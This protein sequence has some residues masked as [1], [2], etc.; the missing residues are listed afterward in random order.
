M[1]NLA[2]IVYL[3]KSMLCLIL[4]PPLIFSFVLS[5]CDTFKI[6][7]QDIIAVAE[8]VF[9]IHTVYLNKYSISV[10]IPFLHVL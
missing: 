5:K 9:S 3:N 7:S 4:H 8:H 10:R 1:R 6:Y 2:Y